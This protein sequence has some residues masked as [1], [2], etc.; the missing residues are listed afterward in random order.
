MGV[1]AWRAHLEGAP[2]EVPSRCCP[3]LSGAEEKSWRSVGVKGLEGS[4]REALSA[5]AR[6]RGRGSIGD[7]RLR[8]S[9]RVRIRHAF[10]HIG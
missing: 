9:E 2:C 7:T 6:R 10:K 1:A 5:E 4:L 8:C 3:P